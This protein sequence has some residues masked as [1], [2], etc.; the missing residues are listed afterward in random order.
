[1]SSD[2]SGEDSAR[3]GEGR[4]LPARSVTVRP[5]RLLRLD[6][7]RPIRLIGPIRLIRLIYHGSQQPL[8]KAAAEFLQERERGAPLVRLLPRSAWRAGT[9][10][11]HRFLSVALPKMSRCLSLQ[12][13]SGG[14][15]QGAGRL[16]RL[17]HAERPG[18]RYRARRVYRSCDPPAP[19]A[20]RRPGRGR[21]VARPFLEGAP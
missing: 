16:H 20:R 15:P 2:R 1:M 8:R 4:N 17:S 3:P 10:E 12:G 7:R 19:A 6:R 14:T 5:F 21:A 11:A 13:E 18:P 9:S